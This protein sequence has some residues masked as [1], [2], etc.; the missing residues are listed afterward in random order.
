MKTENLICRIEGHGKLAIDLEENKARLYVT[1]GERLFE[2]LVVGRDYHQAPF[3]A[4]RICGVCPV[5]HS[6]AAI[7]ALEQALQV[8]V[9]PLVIL[10]RK[11]MLAAQIIQSHLL[12]LFFLTLPDY[13][14]YKSIPDLIKDFPSQY[15]L[16]LAIKRVT[17][18]LLQTLT[19]RVI[20]PIT[21]TVGGFLKL[22]D[23]EQL[24][25]L[26]LDFEAVLDEA[27]D[28]VAQFS[29]LPYPR[30][31]FEPLQLCLSG[32][33]SYSIEGR[34]VIS[35]QK[36]SFKPEFYQKF[37]KEEVK[38]DSAAKYSKIGSKGFMVGAL[39]R[40]NLQER[41]LHLR[42]KKALEKSEIDLPLKNPFL[43]NFAQSVEVLHFLE[44]IL[45]TLYYLSKEENIWKEEI[46]RPVVKKMGEGA[47]A[48]E[49]P[50]GTLYYWFKIE[51][52][53][54]VGCDIIT[55]TAQNLT[56]IEQSA[57]LLLAWNKD[58]TPQRK[59]RLVEMLIR[60]F[61]PCITCSVH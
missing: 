40:L 16:V 58:K 22:P 47:A 10:L 61:D 34:E 24:F 31:N 27:E 8:K 60:A 6:L 13:S 17:D 18:Q 57:N 48:I 15:H 3:I 25:S 45:R 41:Y 36:L 5:A 30:L 49:A 43:N 21:P 4:C 26:I 54:V 20:H 50:R 51:N 37:I 7:K 56:C 2:Q 33:D 29:Q 44:E 28:L 23:K 9:S 59:Q 39:S 55:P 1:H 12:H 53:Q 32:K 14:G 46:L 35:S 19:G 52:E 11:L 42:A 38:F